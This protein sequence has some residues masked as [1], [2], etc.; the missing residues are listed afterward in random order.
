MASRRAA[1]RAS[2][3]ARLPQARSVSSPPAALDRA[4]RRRLRWVTSTKA[5]QQAA[6]G[7]SARYAESALRC[8]SAI[9]LSSH[10]ATNMTEIEPRRSIAMLKFTEDHE[11]LRIEG[12]VPTVAITAHPQQQP[13]ALVLV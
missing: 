9:Y 8:K 4:C 10:I 2:T 3:P 12:D 1:A 11:W 7:F 6:N 13:A 5:R